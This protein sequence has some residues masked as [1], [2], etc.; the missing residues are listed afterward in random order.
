M[1][2]DVKKNIIIIDLC[3]NIQILFIFINHR[4]R[5]RATIYNNN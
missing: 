1:I 3:K 2:F 4:S 5:I